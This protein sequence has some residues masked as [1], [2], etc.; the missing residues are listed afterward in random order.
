MVVNQNF[1]HHRSRGFSGAVILSSPPPPHNAR[2]TLELT[3]EASQALEEL[4]E[5][6]GQDVSELFRKS[7][8]LY[9]LAKEAEKDGMAIGA[10]P[11]PE[12]LETQF[13]G[14]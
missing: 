14:F 6:T 13:T 8:A 5:S 9:K 3:K 7:L 11:Q 12:A 10:T 4:M 2:I 1:E